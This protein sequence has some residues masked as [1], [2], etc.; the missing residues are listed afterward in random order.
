MN[1]M[2]LTGLAA[3][4]ASL[5]LAVLLTARMR[6]RGMGVWAMMCET[7]VAIVSGVL[8]LSD[9]AAVAVYGV[10]LTGEPTR[11][12][13]GLV[14]RLIVLALVLVGMGL[15][16]ADTGTGG[17]DVDGGDDGERR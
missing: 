4:V 7:V 13:G 5:V 17:G 1:W 14:G 8:C 3:S 6:R 15:S 12:T 10:D 11:T 16:K 2:D 9:I